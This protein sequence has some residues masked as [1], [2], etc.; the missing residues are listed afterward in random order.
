MQSI[1]RTTSSGRRG[2]L[3][4]GG[5]LAA[6]CVLAVA[7][8]GGCSPAGPGVNCFKDDAIP[9]GQWT[10]PSAAAYREIQAK[11]AI[12][13]RGWSASS[14]EVQSGAVPHFPLWWEDPF[15]DKGSQDNQFAWTYEDYV[16]F[17]YSNARWLLNTMLWPV[18][19]VV[20]PPGTTMLS[21]GQL[22]RGGLGYDHDAA[23]G[24]ARPV[25]LEPPNEVQ[26][27]QPAP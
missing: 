18:S 22:S 20:T 5:L 8:W 6:A 2:G 23:R 19:A 24:T 9:R 7:T 15:E 26:T 1:W 17:P 21:D 13:E 3:V 10:T 25:S 14:A 16:A 12:R 27:S 4:S 11:P